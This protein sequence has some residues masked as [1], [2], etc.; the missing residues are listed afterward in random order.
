M[1]FTKSEVETKQKQMVWDGV[2]GV[3]VLC[4]GPQAA[5]PRE[6]RAPQE[7]QAPRSHHTQVQDY[8]FYTA[9]DCWKL[10]KSDVLNKYFLAP[11]DFFFFF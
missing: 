8:D 3:C 10:S 5:Q 2:A 4:P 1:T 7:G 9:P 11:L 6:A